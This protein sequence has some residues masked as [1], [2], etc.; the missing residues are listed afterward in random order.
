MCLYGWPLSHEEPICVVVA[1]VDVG[2]ARH[3]QTARHGG[4]GRAGRDSQGRH[5]NSA[6]R[7]ETDLE[8]QHRRTD[9]QRR[10]HPSQQTGMVHQTCAALP[11]SRRSASSARTQCLSQATQTHNMSGRQ[12]DR[13]HSM[14]VGV[15]SDV[16]RHAHRS[17]IHDT[18]VMLEGRH[19]YRR[20]T[21]LTPRAGPRCMA[22]LWQRTHQTRRIPG[23]EVMGVELN[24]GKPEYLI[25]TFLKT[26]WRVGTRGD[27]LGHSGY[28]HMFPDT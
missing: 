15:E 2:T 19:Q 27:R 3:S 17:V 20:I 28:A 21:P 14:S 6:V 8:C 23:C 16:R 5:I 4:F 10:D 9:H 24:D 13:T 12:P 1:V 26:M 25:G 18:H 7:D 11:T 22:Q